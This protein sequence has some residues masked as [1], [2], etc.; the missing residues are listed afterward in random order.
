M[1]LSERR[2]IYSAAYHNHHQK[3]GDER[4]QVVSGDQVVDGDQVKRQVTARDGHYKGRKALFVERLTPYQQTATLHHQQHKQQQQQQ[5]QR[6]LDGSTQLEA[7]KQQLVT[8]NVAPATKNQS[9][10]LQ[11]Q[12]TKFW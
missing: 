3:G 6:G 10:G 11:R 2:K 5:Q 4:G 1:S 7:E 9:I 8:L 12:V